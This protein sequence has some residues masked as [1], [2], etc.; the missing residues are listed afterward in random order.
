ME[1]T[2]DLGAQFRELYAANQA[3]MKKRLEEIDRERRRLP[4]QEGP[5]RYFDQERLCMYG[6]GQCRS[7]THFEVERVGHC[8]MH[9]LRV[10]NIMTIN[11]G[12]KE[13]DDD[14]DEEDEE[15]GAEGSDLSA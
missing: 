1:A 6:D 13:L 9:A 15:G 8:F 14:S 11:L 3:A 5:L 4:T 10:L 12:W 7:P 2:T